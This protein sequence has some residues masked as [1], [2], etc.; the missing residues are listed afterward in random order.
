[1]NKE[2]NKTIKK[3]AELDKCTWKEEDY[4]KKIKHY[5]TNGYAILCHCSNCPHFKKGETK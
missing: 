2:L 4:C 5:I 1:M 3:L